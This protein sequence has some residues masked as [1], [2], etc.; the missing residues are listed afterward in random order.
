MNAGQYPFM[1]YPPTIFSYQR[2][3]G[4]Q[5]NQGNHPN[6]LSHLDLNLTK[7]DIQAMITRVIEKAS[8]GT[9]IS[10]I[11]ISSH[12]SKMYSEGTPFS[13]RREAS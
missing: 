4:F 3:G 11:S 8:D 12:I 1:T 7:M 6:V 13:K 2:Y 10:D 5:Y 9:K